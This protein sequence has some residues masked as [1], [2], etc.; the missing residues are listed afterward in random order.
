M[1]GIDVIR[2]IHIR[3]FEDHSGVVNCMNNYDNVI[4]D[5]VQ[6]LKYLM[7]IQ[8]A[9]H[10]LQRLMCFCQTHRCLY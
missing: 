4:L 8:I 6:L 5:N 3:L 1:G 7:V 9:C 10:T 2:T